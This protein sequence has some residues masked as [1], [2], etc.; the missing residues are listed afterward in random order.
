[1]YFFCFVYPHLLTY[2]ITHSLLHAG[3]FGFFGV[4]CKFCHVCNSQEVSLLVKIRVREGS[5]LFGNSNNF[6]DPL[7]ISL[8][9]LH[10]RPVYSEMDGLLQVCVCVHF[11]RHEQL[12]YNTRTAGQ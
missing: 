8:F 4:F 12:A 3:F 11:L 2:S 6:A 5:V 7:K 9:K 10:F 1:M